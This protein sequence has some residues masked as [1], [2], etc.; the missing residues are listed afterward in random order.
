MACRSDMGGALRQ[1]ARTVKLDAVPVDDR[2]E[3]GADGAP[4]DNVDLERQ[5]AL[6][7]SFGE[8]GKLREGKGFASL[9]G[10]VQ[11]G[12][13]LRRTLGAAAEDAN[14]ESLRQMRGKSVL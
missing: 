3:S 4:V 6:A 14:C 2:L 13:R 11:V 8:I 10:E 9:D 1:R 12:K 5:V 7:E